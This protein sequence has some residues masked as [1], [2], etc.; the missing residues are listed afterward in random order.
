[1]TSS[2]EIS[3]PPEFSPS[4]KFLL[5]IEE[6]KTLREEI[7]R[8][9]TLQKQSLIA[10]IVGIGGAL[11]GSVASSD[12]LAAVIE[13]PYLLLL[14][15]LFLAP[16]GITYFEAD[17]S[18]FNAARYL[19]IDLK[20]AVGTVS[21]K[22]R[23]FWEW[24]E[25]RRR[26]SNGNPLIN[27]GWSQVLLF[28]LPSPACVAEFF[29]IIHYV[30]RPLMDTPAKL[31]NYFLVFVDV[32]LMIISVTFYFRSRSEYARIG[33]ELTQLV[34]EMRSGVIA[35]SSNSTTLEA[36]EPQP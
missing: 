18:I 7:G 4:Y 31:A 34:E 26:G 15:P 8:F 25:F 35:T 12:K 36:K 5:I 2:P 6:Y 3:P 21:S 16:L 33:T 17:I 32:A 13:R 30:K 20:K 24:E 28:L 1:M 14:F 11:L 23:G 19:G 29:F 27:F 9:Q 10:S 22:L